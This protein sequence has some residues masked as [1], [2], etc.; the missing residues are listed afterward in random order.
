MSSPTA[1]PANTPQNYQFE[2]NATGAESSAPS[3]T[4][5]CSGSE[6]SKKLDNGV[7]KTSS[8]Q[9]CLAW[10]H[11]HIIGHDSPFR[12]RFQRG[13]IGAAADVASI[14]ILFEVY[15]GEKLALDLVGMEDWTTACRDGCRREEFFN[16]DSESSHDKHLTSL[17][18]ELSSGRIILS[19]G[20]P[21]LSV[22]LLSGGEPF[23]SIGLLSSGGLL[24]SVG[25]F[26]PAPPRISS[27]S[28]FRA[29]FESRWPPLF[30]E[31]HC[32][33][34]DDN[35]TSRTKNT[36]DVDKEK[37]DMLSDEA[38]MD[39]ELA[40]WEAAAV[41]YNAYAKQVGFGIRRR[42][43]RKSRGGEMRRVMWVCAKEGF[44][45]SKWLNLSGCI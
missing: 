10:V 29:V 43:V 27:A 35:V 2:I 22:G 8:S 23:L 9:K 30:G 37:C 28:S 24:L 38:I 12:S 3:S 33:G 5:L 34:V 4:D 18:I 45:D 16:S 39:M 21:F 42:D 13:E 20:E 14:V 1:A 6:S 11:S 40:S 19:G 15:A 44:R 7:L 31:L 32:I 17:P 25:L 26:F 41:F 36:G